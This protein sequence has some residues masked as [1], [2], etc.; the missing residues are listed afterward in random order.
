VSEPFDAM[1]EGAECYEQYGTREDNPYKPSTSEY[2]AWDIGYSNAKH[3]YYHSEEGW[4]T[5]E[6]DRL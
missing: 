6:L 2:V 3:G 4:K 1:K 5:D